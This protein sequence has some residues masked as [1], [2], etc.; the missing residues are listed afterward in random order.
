MI[1]FNQGTKIDVHGL[2]YYAV[3]NT[4][5]IKLFIPCIQIII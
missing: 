1:F 3:Y 5:Y 2:M 4:Q